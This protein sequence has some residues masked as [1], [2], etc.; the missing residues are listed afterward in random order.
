[1]WGR[2]IPNGSGEASAVATDSAGNVYIPFASDSVILQKYDINGNS[3]WPWKKQ[4]KGLITAIY[5]IANDPSANS[6]VLGTFPG[7]TFITDPPDTL[8]INTDTLI[9]QCNDF[10]YFLVK[11]DA[12]GNVKWARQSKIIGPETGKGESLYPSSVTCDKNGNAFVTGY[13]Q[14][15]YLIGKDSVSKDFFLV[16]YDPYG[17]VLWVKQNDSTGFSV[18]SFVA[19]DNFGHEYVAINFAGAIKFGSTTL[20]STPSHWENCGVVKYDESGNVIWAK[21]ATVPS[22][23]SWCMPYSV[24]TDR[25]G[26]AYVTGSFQDTVSFGS[27]IL[28][29]SNSA[30][31]FLAKYDTAGNVI[32]AKQSISLDGNA[33]TGYSL[34]S[35]T[36]NHIYLSGGTL[37]SSN[38]GKIQFG[39]TIYSSS[40][41][42]DP[43]VLVE[44]DTS[45]NVICGASTQSGGDDANGVATDPSGQYIYL[46][47]D[48]YRHDILGPDTITSSNEVDFVARWQPCPETTVSIPGIGNSLQ[49]VSLFPNPNN[50]RF[51]ILSSLTGTNLLVEFYNML[52]QKVANSQWPLANSAIQVDLSSQPAGI[53]LY[54]ITDEQ[55]NSTAKGKFI[56]A[57]N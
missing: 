19:E 13:N 2:S 26:N 38:T 56:I 55:G 43:S 23:K 17:N 6:F 34:A 32:W 47:G 5:S 44:F 3:L 9:V 52:G 51:T 8:F 31:I 14:G 33:W 54:R 16:K 45:G 40:N 57:G 37:A 53:Y 4:T 11:F 41:C 50:G 24:V 10:D 21:Q 30:A 46:G 27:Y 29:S 15:Y 22:T 1:M 36:L 39:T 35:D 12:S 49:A 7:P 20:F 25:A 48:V 28:K 42:L 18:Q